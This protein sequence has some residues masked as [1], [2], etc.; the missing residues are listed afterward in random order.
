M[1]IDRKL[2]DT[3]LQLEQ[4]N[5]PTEILNLISSS[6]S[7]QDVGNKISELRNNGMPDNEIYGY[8]KTAKTSTSETTPTNNSDSLINKIGEG[9]TWLGD[10]FEKKRQEWTTPTN[11]ENAKVPEWG[12]EN[13]NAYGLLG[14]IREAGVPV[15]EGVALGSNIT[16]VGLL[17]GGAKYAGVNQ[18]ASILDKALGNKEQ[19]TLGDQALQA[20]KDTAIGATLQG[21]AGL[22]VPAIKAVSKFTKRGATEL[23]GTTTGSG[24]GM[25]QEALKGGK[26]F[27]DAMRGK[28]TGDEIVDNTASA[29]RLLKEQRQEAYAKQ[30]ENITKNETPID[31][32]NISDKLNNLLKSY[33]VE[34]KIDGLPKVDNPKIQAQLS[35][36]LKDAPA[37]LNFSKS[38]LG[39]SAQRDVEEIV[40]LVKNW[41]DNTPIGLD[42]LKRRLADFYSESSQARQ[43]VA[44]LE[45][46][47]KRTI[48][49]AVP[50]Y[51]AMT[52]GYREATNLIKEVEKGLMLQKG[53]TG[54]QTLRRL[55]SAMRE[56][57]E[58]R[59]DL[60]NILGQKSGE[61][62]AGQI[63]G[64]SANQLIPRGLV[65]KMSLGGFST[66]AY[67]HP[68]YW[69]LLVASSPRAVG[70]FLYYFGKGVKE[71]KKVEPLVS[72]TI[73]ATGVVSIDKEKRKEKL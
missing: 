54:D 53:Q 36:A 4:D 46:E 3:A 60:V 24:A 12:R 47:V 51:D 30:L 57:F 33:R 19:T 59:K 39:K 17:T 22:A 49:K 2:Q 13:P 27:Q 44:D 50:E 73:K 21:A 6:K 25:T 11:N 8:L 52:K 7:Y 62:L 26:S 29:L 55:T 31:T 38:S 67:L 42:A 18:L 28:I 23:L 48:V 41:E 15:A 1:P 10:T 66:I 70:E 14:A 20:A 40:D 65:G 71:L 58:M 35:E 45:N 16:P 63:A 56:N 37:T 5:S 61:D 32:S 9:L 34:K 68:S 72:P 69:P 64:Y 43:F